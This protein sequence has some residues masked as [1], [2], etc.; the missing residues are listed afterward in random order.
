MPAR[1]QEQ[2]QEL[3]NQLTQQPPLNDAEREELSTL[4]LEIDQQLALG[5]GNT[6]DASLTDGVNLAVERF[7]V[8]HPTVAATLRSIVQS[9]GNMGI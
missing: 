1:L 7:E 4:L 8:E 2:L 9:L 6:A 3:R 5:A